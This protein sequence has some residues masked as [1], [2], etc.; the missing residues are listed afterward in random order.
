MLWNPWVLFQ[1]SAS[2]RPS[3]QDNSALSPDSVV[4]G[5]RVFTSATT[6]KTP[7]T[8][9]DDARAIIE[10]IE[11]IKSMESAAN[12]NH[13]NREEIITRRAANEDILEHPD[14]D[15]KFPSNLKLKS[16]LKEA[17]KRG[18]DTAASQKALGTGKRK[19]MII[20]KLE[21]QL[22]W[23][24][25]FKALVVS[26]V[27]VERGIGWINCNYCDSWRN[28]VKTTGKCRE[29]WLV[30]HR[31]SFFRLKLNPLWETFL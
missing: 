17:V 7:R 1:V 4:L 31:L 2:P 22:L 5:G 10:N 13:A 29:A 23:I 14:S 21:N 28:F 19:S 20:K 8:I 3:R 27:W 11:D 24:D 30:T 26:I 18:R 25:L 15:K 12:N 6:R 16:L 9:S